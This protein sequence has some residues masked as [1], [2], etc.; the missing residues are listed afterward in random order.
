MESLVHLLS[1]VGFHFAFHR[2]AVLQIAAKSMRLEG[3]GITD[4]NG[5]TAYKIFMASSSGSYRT[6]DIFR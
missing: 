6:I 3:D 4:T 5:C 1:K 2:V